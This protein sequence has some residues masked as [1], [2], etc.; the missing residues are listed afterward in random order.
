M[1]DDISASGPVGLATQE[2]NGVYTMLARPLERGTQEEA[3]RP[4][5]FVCHAVAYKNPGDDSLQIAHN[6]RHTA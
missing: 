1:R 4:D 2:H 3:F 6:Y 5:Q